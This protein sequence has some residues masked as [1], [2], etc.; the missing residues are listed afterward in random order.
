[1]Q[2]EEPLMLLNLPAS[3]AVHDIAAMLEETLPRLQAEQDDAPPALNKPGEHGRQVVIPK[4][5]A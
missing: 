1:M 3:H 4:E 2:K 5:S